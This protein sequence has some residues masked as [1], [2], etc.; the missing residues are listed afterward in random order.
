[1]A[2]SKPATRTSSASDVKIASYNHVNGFRV[3]AAAVGPS[4]DIIRDE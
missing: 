3:L 2:A 1:M 4:P